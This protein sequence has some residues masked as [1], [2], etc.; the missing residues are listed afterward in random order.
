MNTAH[1]RYIWSIWMSV[2]VIQQ[3]APL[4]MDH[5]AKFIIDWKLSS[6][7]FCMLCP[8][9]LDHRLFHLEQSNG[10]SLSK[11]PITVI[12]KLHPSS[13]VGPSFSTCHHHHHHEQSDIVQQ[14]K[15][16]TRIYKWKKKTNTNKRVLIFD[17]AFRSKWNSTGQ[18]TPELDCINKIK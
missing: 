6:I 13:L 1:P 12:F 7:L 15:K 4:W 5:S 18:A 16:H 17:T 3:W 2:W 8:F 10:R 9:I 14:N 11:W